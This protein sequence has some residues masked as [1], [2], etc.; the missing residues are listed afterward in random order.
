M[1][2]RT[3]QAADFFVAPTGTYQQLLVLVIVPIIRDIHGLSWC[4]TRLYWPRRS[5]SSITRN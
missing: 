4:R 5:T 1:R 2:A 3:P